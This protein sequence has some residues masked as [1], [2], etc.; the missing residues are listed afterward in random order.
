MN[1]ALARLL[2]RLYPRPWR[3]RY[4]AEFEALLLDGH[5]G[6]G[7]AANVA[8][9]AVCERISPTQGGKMNRDPLSFGGV[10][11]KPSAFLP[12][13]MSLAALAVVLGHIA[14]YGAVREA[15]E[16]AAAHIWQL[17]MA[18]QLP[19]VAFFAIKWLPRS[20]KAALGVLGLQ[21]GAVLAS[22]A[23]VFYFNL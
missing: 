23:P 14:I 19:V 17:L 4:G 12:L 11:R 16:G 1:P 3:E 13:A 7:T 9:S 21:A 15:D 22:M 2:T 20:P 5:G 6:L 8:W 10:T 18:G